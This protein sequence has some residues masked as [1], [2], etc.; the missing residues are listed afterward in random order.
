VET[1]E[2]R[3]GLKIACV[4]EIAF[5]QNWISEDQLLDLAKALGKTGYAKYLKDLVTN[6]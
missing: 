1:I 2:T 5:Q 6:S 3:Q 4:E